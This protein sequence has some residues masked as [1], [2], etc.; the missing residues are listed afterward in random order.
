MVGDLVAVVYCTE[1]L[2]KGSWA[3]QQTDDQQDPKTDL[4][5]RLHRNSHPGRARRQPITAFHAA[6]EWLAFM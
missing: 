1:T 3:G 6:G 2:Q 4:G 5:H